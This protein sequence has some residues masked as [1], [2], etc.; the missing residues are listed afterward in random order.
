MPWGTPDEVIDRIKAAAD[1]A[2][3]PAEAVRQT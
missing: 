2:G 3:A 1:H